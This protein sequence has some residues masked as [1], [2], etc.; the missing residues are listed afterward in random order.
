MFINLHPDPKLNEARVTEY[1]QAFIIHFHSASLFY[2]YINIYMFSISIHITLNLLLSFFN[3]SI[4]YCIWQRNYFRNLTTPL[5]EGGEQ[6]VRE[7]PGQRVGDDDTS[8]GPTVTLPLPRVSSVFFPPTPLDHQPPPPRD[9]QFH[10]K[11]P[12][13]G[14]PQQCYPIFLALQASSW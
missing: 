8:P 5:R 14:T 7:K 10:P 1:S 9:F 11:S 4:C 13:S 3:F 2:S 12:V 6:Y